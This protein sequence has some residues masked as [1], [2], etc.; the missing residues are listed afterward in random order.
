MEL[1]CDFF[2]G[3][4]SAQVC[5]KPLVHCPVILHSRAHFL[6]QAA[7]VGLDG[8]RLGHIEA[9]PAVPMGS[10]VAVAVVAD[11]LPQAHA[12]LLDQIQQQHAVTHILRRQGNHPAKAQ[13]GQLRHGVFIALCSLGCQKSFIPEGR[14]HGDFFHVQPQRIVLFKV[15]RT[16]ALLHQLSLPAQTHRGFAGAAYLRQSGNIQIQTARFQIL[17]SILDLKTL[18][19]FQDGQ[20]LR[21]RNRVAHLL[22]EKVIVPRTFFKSNFKRIHSKKSSNPRLVPIFCIFS[23]A[24]RSICR[25]RSLE[26]PI[27]RPIS[28]RE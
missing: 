1:F 8:D 15:L 17:Q 20:K 25:T 7:A 5:Q 28:S 9:D 3:G 26:I 16:Q 21:C 14:G 22:G 19:P 11:G 13:I 27:C 10:V 24:W 6:T 18:L 23:M 12:A 2:Q 4:V